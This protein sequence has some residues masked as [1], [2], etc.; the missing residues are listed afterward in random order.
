[1]MEKIVKAMPDIQF[2]YFGDESKKGQ[3]GSNFEHLGYVK[4]SDWMPKLSC[5]LRISFHDGYPLLPVEFI[6]AGRN[7]VTN[8][9][10]K[11][12]SIHV[13]KELKDIIKGIRYAQKNPINPKWAKYLKKELNFNLYK[14][15]I[16]GLC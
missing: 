1:M 3:K 12:G 13:E 15:R 8:V 16:N 14:R 7:V 5:N 4:M 10:M 11:R 2:Y 6:T 9:P